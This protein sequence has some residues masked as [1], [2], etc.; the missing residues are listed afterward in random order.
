METLE[1]ALSE[2]TKRSGSVLVEHSSTGLTRGLEVGET[3]LVRDGL[4]YRLGSVADVTFELTDTAYR[5][6][7]GDEIDADAAL[8]ARRDAML[9]DAARSGSVDTFELLGLLRAARTIHEQNEFLRTHLGEHA[10]R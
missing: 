2:F 8:A 6:E 9:S 3:L 4:S 5:L 1:L 7:L 10:S